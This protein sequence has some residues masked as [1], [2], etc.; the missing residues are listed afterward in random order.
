M[1][2]RMGD[3][4][5]R[6]NNGFHR[7]SGRQSSTLADLPIDVHQRGHLALSGILECNNPPRTLLGDSKQ[8]LLCKIIY[9]HHHSINAEWKRCSL[10]CKGLDRN[11][12]VVRAC[13]LNR[14]IIH[15][16]VPLFQCCNKFAVAVNLWAANTFATTMRNEGKPA[17]CG[18]SR[19]ETLDRSNSRISCIGE[20]RFITQSA[21]CIDAVKFR[22]RHIDFATNFQYIW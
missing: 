22:I 19:I 14:K 12:G 16:N 11:D 20:Q 3:R 18:N 7:C 10:K 6:N 5:T 9:S 8:F 4:R 21:L 1:Q 17:R 2:R 13:T 15:R